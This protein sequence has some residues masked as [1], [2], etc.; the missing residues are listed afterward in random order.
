MEG[1][2]V[3]WGQILGEPVSEAIPFHRNWI[4]TTSRGKWVV[5]RIR[6]PGHVRWWL[7]VER[8]MRLRGFTPMPT[9]RTDGVRWL[10]T[11]WIEG[12]RASYRRKED[13]QVVADLLGRF[14]RTGRG[15]TIHPLGNGRYNLAEKVRSRFRSFFSLVK[16]VGNRGEPGALLRSYGQ[17]FCEYGRE[18][19]QRLEQLPL[20]EL[21]AW[22]RRTHSL[23]HRDLASHNI[24][25]GDQAWLIDFETADYDC[26]VGDLWQ[27]LSR[28]LSEQ[29]WDGR[30]AWEVLDA[31]EAHRSLTPPE[32]QVLAA[33]FAFPNEFFREALGLFH[34][35]E[36]YGEAKT[37]PYL[38]K[39][40]RET[41]R[42]RS[43]L[44]S[45]DGW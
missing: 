38:Q 10:L 29:G 28:G 31:Y 35:K 41:P 11:E 8:E 9:I 2:M 36:G 1:H 39:L 16:E 23:T 43:F 25:L 30:V 6:H 32:K 27:L 34:Q 37:L 24:L 42:W 17:E 20:V 44:Q 13:I 4:V 5:K 22:D 12:K 14:H 18:A 26:Q 19:L 15:L 33:L 7:W 21:C 45:L 40:A 3:E